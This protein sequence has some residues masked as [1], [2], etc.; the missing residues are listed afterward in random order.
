MDWLHA[1]DQ[2]ITADHIGNIFHYVTENHIPGAN[3]EA[4]YNALWQEIQAD[5]EA[6]DVADRL[7]CLK[8]SFVEK[9]QGMKLRCSAAVCRALVPIVLKLVTE[10]LDIREPVE[11]AMYWATYHLDKCYA[12]LSKDFVGDYAATLQ[13]SST[14][15]AL[16]YVALH[17]HFY[18]GDDRL[19]R[20]KPK[21]HFF[22]HLC[23]DGG[24]P[25]RNWLYRN[26]DFG[27]SVAKAAHRRGGQASATATSYN[28]LTKLAIGTPRIAAR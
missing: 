2:G 11:E 24:H 21:L 28:V 7:D 9:R 3:K 26:E 1:A 18:P 5:Y 19:F 12:C 14:K 23:S 20:L 13:E 10:L 8:P 6:N 25:A 22:L 15:F 17:D 16:Q 4:R 27:G